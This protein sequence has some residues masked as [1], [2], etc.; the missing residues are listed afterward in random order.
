MRLLIALA[1]ALP[2]LSLL[3]AAPVEGAGT[4]E[5]LI[6]EINDLLE[7]AAFS[8]GVSIL[9][10]Q[11]EPARA[12]FER[13]ADQL[14]IPASNNK[15]HTT[16][17]ALHFLGP[18][19]TL[20]T[21]VVT[22]GTV[23][24]AGVLEGDL[25]VIGSG[26][27]TISGRFN[28][29]NILG[30]FEQWAT[31][32]QARGIRA[33]AG[34]IIGDDDLFDDE[35]IEETWSPRELGEWYSAES[36]AL[37]LNDNCVDL[38][39]TAGPTVG[40]PASWTADPATPYLT[41]RSEVRTVAEGTET[42]RYYR[43]AADSN[44]VRVTGG[45]PLGQTNTDYAAVHNPTLFAVTV[46]RDVLQR[47]GIQVSGEAVD[48]DDLDK[49]AV[50]QSLT[51]LTSFTSPPLSTIVDIVNQHSQN[52]YAD[53]V[54][55]LIGREVEGEGSFD[56]GVRAVRRHLDEIGALPPGWQ[57]L[58]GSG[59]SGQNR[60]T[61]R[62]LVTLIRAMMSSPH[63]ETFLASL[64]RGRAERGSLRRRFG[65]TARSRAVAGQIQGKTGYIGG[66][67]ALSGTLTNQA[68]VEMIYSLV[69]NR[70]ESESTP[71]LQLLDAIA[72]AAA[73]STFEADAPLRPEM[74]AQ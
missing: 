39:W 22:N 11:R 28:G 21:R 23:N 34:R 47:Q 17:A 74:A 54:L 4:P 15:L 46:L 24:E 38:V 29:G 9:I 58:D 2:S 62:C 65:Q 66:V 10:E 64:P 18:D 70:Y 69:L 14:V 55:K 61:P 67:Y 33:I 52:F 63:S 3:H 32:L 71:P 37:S 1:L 26:D 30:T 50:R 59:L 16:A 12:L 73:A 60:T 44:S 41:I 45:I 72:V 51:E 31:E 49:S 36:S 25:I 56:A 6:Q 42:D 68:G 35:L 43:R 53:M 27:P 57:M 48:I 5:A 8:G 7:E 19:L 40:S 13:Q 20:T